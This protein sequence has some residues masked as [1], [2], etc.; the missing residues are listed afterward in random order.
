MD[1]LLIFGSLL[2]VAYISGLFIE[3]AGLPKILG[4]IITGII[5]NSNNF[6]FIPSDFTEMTRPIMEICLAFIA[7]EVGGELKWNKVKNHEK[8]IISITF[9]A[10]LLPYLLIVAGILSFYLFFPEYISF[11]FPELFLF[12]LLLGA[13][14]SPTAPA[15]TLA[16]IHQYRSKGDVSDTILGV[17]AL[18]DVLGIIIFSITLVMVPIFMESSNEVISGSHF[19]TALYKIFFAILIGTVLAF[20]IKFIGKMLKIK[21]EKEWVVI[22]FSIIILCVGLT[23]HFNV[24]ELLA[25]MTMGVVVV[26]I[27][28]K[29]RAIFNITERYTENLVF[30]IF[31]LLSGMHLDIN[32]IPEALPLIVLFVIMRVVG[33][34]FGVYT[35]ASIVKANKNVRRYTAGGLLP[36]AG[37]AIGLVLSIYQQKGFEEI[38]ELLLT[39]IMG[40]TVINEIIGPVIAKYSLEKSGE[41]NPHS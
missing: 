7:F 31:F 18:D 2:F 24:D 39:I 12:A 5:F 29:E 27:C 1:I 26:N 3:K 28:K 19:Y 9:L 20:A 8:E 10:S 37:V 41:I 25:Y 15:A 36:Q 14:A 38:S 40:A 22:I 17:V 6:D 13:L 23:K 11:G 4:Y 32:V 21:G 16:V 34:Y 33:K 35:G 30:L